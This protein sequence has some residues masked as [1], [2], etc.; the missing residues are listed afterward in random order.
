MQSVKEGNCR[1]GADLAQVGFYEDSRYLKLGFLLQDAVVTTLGTFQLT[2]VVTDSPKTE[3]RG[4]KNYF[5]E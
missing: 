1:F 5:G 3:V 4:A 2:K